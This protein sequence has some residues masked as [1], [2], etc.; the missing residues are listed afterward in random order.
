MINN[1]LLDGGS[2]GECYNKWIKGKISVTYHHPNQF[3]SIYG[4]LIFH[5]TNP[6]GLIPML[7]LES[8]A[9]IT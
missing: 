8:T 7:G 9:Y 4:W 2:K 3:H 6:W 5:S 1:V